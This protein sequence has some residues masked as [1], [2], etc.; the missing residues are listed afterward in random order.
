MSSPRP[1]TRSPLFLLGVLVVAAVAFTVLLS[2]GG[3]DEDDTT[4]AGVAGA[5]E[6]A[7]VEII[8]D[9]L[10]PFDADDGALGRPAPGVTGVSF[11]GSTVDLSEPAP[12]IFGFFAH[13]CPHCQ[14]EL[15]VVQE[16]VEAGLVPDGVE[17]VAVS[18]SVESSADNYPPSAWFSD[19]GYDATVIVDDGDS[20]IARSFGLTGFPFW[21]VTDDDGTVIRRI[22]GGIDEARFEEMGQQALGG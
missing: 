12:R 21:V 2:L 1:F 4:T 11:D 14:R 7:D 5:T 6:V 8:G 18:T 15:P 10:E 22:G 19:V 16:W 17:F 9:A 20:T 3:D 13:W